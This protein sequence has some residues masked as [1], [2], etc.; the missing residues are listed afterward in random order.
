M[1]WIFGRGKTRT[2]KM[3]IKKL[4][5]HNPK[6]LNSTNHCLSG[7]VV[8]VNYVKD[9]KDGYI[10]EIQANYN[11]LFKL[12]INKVVVDKLITIQITNNK[13]NESYVTYKPINFCNKRDPF[14]DWLVKR[15]EEME[16]NGLPF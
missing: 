4:N 15:V 1:Y 11:E 3:A 9:D 2:K 6:R 8:I 12:S 7:T 5:I 16:T 10:Y 13:T 14:L